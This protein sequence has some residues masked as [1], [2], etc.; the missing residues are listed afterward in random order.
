VL[1]MAGVISLINNFLN[2]RKK[3]SLLTKILSTSEHT[4]Y[5][6]M[7]EKRITK[8]EDKETRQP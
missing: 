8:V 4:P 7:A 3:M 2:K 5:F 6:T 1:L